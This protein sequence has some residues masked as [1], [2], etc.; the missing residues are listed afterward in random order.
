M[1]Q[2]RS[3][4]TLEVLS[5]P[6]LG[7]LSREPMTMM[8]SMNVGGPVLRDCSNVEEAGEVQESERCRDYRCLVMLGHSL[9]DECHVMPCRS[10]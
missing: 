9:A 4:V 10:Y 8:M 5:T 2:N 6:L 1:S 3:Q 7:V